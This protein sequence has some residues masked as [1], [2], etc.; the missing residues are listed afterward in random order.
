MSGKYRW[1]GHRRG[2][3]KSR[4]RKSLKLI[5]CFYTEVSSPGNGREREIGRRDVGRPTG[6]E[7]GKRAERKCEANKWRR[8]TKGGEIDL[9][10]VQSTSRHFLLNSA[11]EGP[12][13]ANVYE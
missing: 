9:L 8:K 6:K 2:E 5:N 1:L 11:R 3:I 4:H 7:E 13:V 12:T 10:R